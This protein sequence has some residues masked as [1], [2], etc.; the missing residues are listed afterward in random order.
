M[1]GQPGQLVGV[2]SYV[3]ELALQQPILGGQ[4][5]LELSNLG[6][7]GLVSIGKDLKVADLL[8]DELVFV[9]DVVNFEF[10]MTATGLRGKRVTAVLREKGKTAVLARAEVE[11][12]GDGQ[13]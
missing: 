1:F 8:V 6:V 10:R 12:G 11:I 3:A 13:S 9:D 2:F 4:A 5:V 7:Q